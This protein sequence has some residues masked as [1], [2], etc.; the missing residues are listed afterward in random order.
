MLDDLGLVPAVDW[1]IQ[2]FTQRSGVK[3]SLSI[4]E[5]MELG[6]LY[7][8]AVFRILQEALANVTKHAEATHVKVEIERT[9]DAVA[10]SVSDN[11]QG[12]SLAAPRKPESLG[13]TGLRERVR[14]LKG[15]IAID[16]EP[17]GGVRIAVRLP[18]VE[19]GAAA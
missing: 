4:D 14:L 12:F 19:S 6:E 2:G 18:I 3:C 13:L 15:T 7:A 11:G 5:D 17:G 16:S 10:L 1:L 8:T 9:R